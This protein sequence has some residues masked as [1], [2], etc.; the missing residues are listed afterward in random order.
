[1][2]IL[3]T[4]AIWLHS[5][6]HIYPVVSVLVSMG[7]VSF[8]PRAI[9]SANSYGGGLVDTFTGV[10]VGGYGSPLGIVCDAMT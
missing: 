10:F 1:M 9:A 4:I 3:F 6:V 7:G 5:Y 2:Y 8:G